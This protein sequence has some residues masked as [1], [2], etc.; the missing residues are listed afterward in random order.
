[1]GG[2]EGESRKKKR[3]NRGK[4]KKALGEKE[5]I[6]KKKLRKINGGNLGSGLERFHLVDLCLNHMA[7]VYK[8]FLPRMENLDSFFHHHGPHFPGVF[9]PCF[10][11]GQ[12]IH[13][14]QVSEKP[15]YWFGQAEV[16]ITDLPYV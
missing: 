4:R 5:R 1:M 12:N 15:A 6:R 9:S 8:V 16:Q 3:K 7:M 10:K 2:G 14:R 13:S 11:L